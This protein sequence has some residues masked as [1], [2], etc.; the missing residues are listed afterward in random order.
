MATWL[1]PGTK[2][3]L[4]PLLGHGKGSVQTVGAGGAIGVELPEPNDYAMYRYEIIRKP[5]R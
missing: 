5:V 4:T 2:V 1:A 3:R